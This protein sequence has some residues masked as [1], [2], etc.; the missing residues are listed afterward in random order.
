MRVMKSIRKIIDLF[1]TPSFS[2]FIIG[3]EG[4]GKTILN[5]ALRDE[6]YDKEKDFGTSIKPVELPE[7]TIT[8]E[9]KNIRIR[10]GV[11][12]TGADNL[13]NSYKKYIRRNTIVVLLFNTEKYMSNDYKEVRDVAG[14]IRGLKEIRDNLHDVYIIGTHYDRVEGIYSKKEVE[15]RLVENLDKEK[16]GIV[17]LID[18]EHMEIMSFGHDDP[19]KPEKRFI[20]NDEGLRNLICKLFKIPTHK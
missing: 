11:D 9:G 6:E 4:I 12:I 7:K 16:C 13:R 19:E 18:S 5:K 3:S 14:R 20:A 8:I 15:K 17:E 2:F 1:Y 10:S